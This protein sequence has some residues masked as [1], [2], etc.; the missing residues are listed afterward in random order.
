MSITKK[1]LTAGERA[2]KTQAAARQRVIKRGIVQFRADEE[3][4]DL[5]L[6]IAMHKRIPYGVMCRAWVVERLRQEAQAMPYTA[7]AL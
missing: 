3:I 5:L 2:A 1:K 6:R 4:M 7:H